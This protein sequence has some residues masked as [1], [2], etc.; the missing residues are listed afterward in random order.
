MPNLE[1]LLKI[2]L[3]AVR[4]LMLKE[5]FS[6]FRRLRCICKQHAMTITFLYLFAIQI[7]VIALLLHS[8]YQIYPL[9]PSHHVPTHERRHD[10][11][12]R[13]CSMFEQFRRAIGRILV[14]RLERWKDFW[15]HLCHVH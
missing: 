7:I 1:I 14:S 3:V 4:V 11:L 15:S 6:L 2:R 8:F 9:Y 12:W 5:V 10:D 13:S